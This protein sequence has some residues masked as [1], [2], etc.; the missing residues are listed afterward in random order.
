MKIVIAIDSF[1]GSMSSLDAAEAFEIGAKKVYPN[2]EIVKVSLADGGEGTVEALVRGSNGKLI[3][4]DVNGPLMEKTK[5]FYGILGNDNT[6]VLE[7]ASASG[8]TLI[9]IEKRNP[10]ETTTYGT[11][12]LIKDA[13]KKGCRNFIVGIGGSA[14]NDGG[15]G[16]LSALGYKFLDKNKNILSP[17]GKNLININEIDANNVMEELKECKFLVACDVDNPLH[18][19]K[20]AA[21]V[22]GRQ[23]GGTDEIIKELDE[24]LKHYDAVIKKYNGKEI[25]EVKG[26]GAAGGLGGGFIGFLNA[27]LKPGI[28]IVIDAVKLEEKVKDADLVITGEGRI[29]FQTSMGKTPVGVAKVAKKHDVMVVAIAGSVAHDA[30]EVHEHGIDAFFSIMNYPMLLEDAMKRENAM[31]LTEKNSE[32]IM[33]IIKKIKG[34]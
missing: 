20:G 5:S 29:D 8:L 3:N 26:A 13:I 1:K 19:P 27:Q 24:G 22:Y 10:K 33:R 9:P 30:N 21:Y 6:A 2:A 14:T 15:I 11:G 31:K 34:E 32:Q 25:G 28:E 18:G 17:I 4:I 7:M 12:E 23:K 16:M